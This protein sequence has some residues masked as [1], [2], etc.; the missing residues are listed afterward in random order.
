MESNSKD[1]CTI[2][3]GDVIFLQHLNQNEMYRFD[4]TASV[5]S[6]HGDGYGEKFINVT[7]REESECLQTGG[8]CS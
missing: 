3:T 2:L 7:L 6:I 4:N 1:E 5:I 8:W